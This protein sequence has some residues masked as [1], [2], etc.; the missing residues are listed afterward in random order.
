MKLFKDTYYTVEI[1]R[2]NLPI[3]WR[4]IAA[5]S[6]NAKAFAVAK[7]E[8]ESIYTYARVQCVSVFEKD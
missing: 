3:K 4:K 5:C 8:L 6:S 1:T 2:E 7:R